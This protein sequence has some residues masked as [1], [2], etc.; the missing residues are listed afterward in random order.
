[1]VASQSN[2]FSMH[3]ATATVLKNNLARTATTPAFAEVF[4]RFEGLL[5]QIS[6]KDEER[7]GNT[8]EKFAAKDEAEDRW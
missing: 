2:R 7:M 1:M 8:S 3:N 5:N 4:G 6:E